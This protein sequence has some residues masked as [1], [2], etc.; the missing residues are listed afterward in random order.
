M[1]PEPPKLD[2]SRRLSRE[3]GVTLPIPGSPT[4]AGSCHVSRA[5]CLC[6]ARG[7]ERARTIMDISGPPPKKHRGETTEGEAEPVEQDLKEACD[8]GMLHAWLRGT[9]PRDVL[10]PCALGS[11]RPAFA[12]KGDAWSW[13]KC[14]EFLS[15]G[16]PTG[17][18][19]ESALHHAVHLPSGRCTADSVHCVWHRHAS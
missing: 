2:K 4:P 9:Y 5:C 18:Q 1:Q 12:Y 17:P 15:K 16:T 14:D 19:P 11:K 13:E 3:D 7:P 8:L 10:I 6:L